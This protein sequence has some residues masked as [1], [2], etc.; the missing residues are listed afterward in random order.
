M[1]AR[2]IAVIRCDHP[3]CVERFGFVDDREKWQPPRLGE[4][5]RAAYAEGWRHGVR[6]RVD[7]GPAPTFDFCPK[8]ADDVQN[9]SEV[10]P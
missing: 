5:R 9:L 8:H 2:M 3:E 1:S 7:A 10:T 6:R 4:A